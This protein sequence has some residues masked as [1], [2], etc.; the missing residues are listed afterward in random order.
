MHSN[1]DLTCVIRPAFVHVHTMPSVHF[2]IGQHV[3]QGWARHQSSAVV[4]SAMSGFRTHAHAASHQRT[5]S[6]RVWGP[7][8]AGLVKEREAHVLL[9]GLLLGLLL[10]C[11]G[12]AGSCGGS[13]SCGRGSGS[14]LGGVLQVVL[15][16]QGAGREVAVGTSQERPISAQS[17]AQSRPI[18]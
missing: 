16:L 12:L 18:S 2:V 8:V 4:T 15:H 3:R 17:S 14:K 11:G 1:H 10:L 5:P 13:G 7:V 6:S 9:L